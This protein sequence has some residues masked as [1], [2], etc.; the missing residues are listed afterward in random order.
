MSLAYTHQVTFL[1]VLAF[2]AML[3]LVFTMPFWIGVALRG[4]A[5]MFC[6]ALLPLAW[7]MDLPQLWGRRRRARALDLLG[8]YLPQLVAR[9]HSAS[10]YQAL[11]ESGMGA[12]KLEQLIHRHLADTEQE[13]LRGQVIGALAETELGEHLSELSAEHEEM[14]VE[15]RVELEKVRQHNRLLSGMV[16]RLQTKVIEPAEL[17][18][19]EASAAQLDDS[20]PH[21][22]PPIIPAAEPARPAA[23]LE[24]KR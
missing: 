24:E 21:A 8:G 13:R 19:A 12:D 18:E 2:I 5:S 11:V 1:H 10:Y 3:G 9:G 17:A 16:E 23:P 7:L 20:A 15:A 14:L 6:V 4:V 22:A